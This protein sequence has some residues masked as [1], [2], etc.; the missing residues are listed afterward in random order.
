MGQEPGARS[1]KRAPTR[2]A[3]SPGL[4]QHLECGWARALTTPQREFRVAVQQ[5]L[6]SLYELSPTVK[7]LWY[8]SFN[9]SS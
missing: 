2:E 1:L 5:P 7:N 9:L 3:Q 4:P 8:I 6:T